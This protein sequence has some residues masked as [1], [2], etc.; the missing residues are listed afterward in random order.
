M[1]L[2]IAYMQTFSLGTTKVT[3]L[4]RDYFTRNF[5]SSSRLASF[6]TPNENPLL[7]QRVLTL[8]QTTLKALLQ[9]IDT[10]Q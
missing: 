4:A 2:N 3:F 9:A 7:H 6:S 8:K 10:I 5:M 1:K